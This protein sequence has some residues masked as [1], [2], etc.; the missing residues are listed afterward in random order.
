VHKR[1]LSRGWT[2]E[3]GKIPM[4][5]HL[6]ESK[7]TV[8]RVWLIRHAEAVEADTFAGSDLERPLTARG[9]RL[10]RRLFT[11]LVACYPAPGVVIVSKAI[12]ARQTGDVFTRI[13]ATPKSVVDGAVN[14]GAS[15]RSLEAVVAEALKSNDFIVVI[16][17]EPDF[18][19]YA[20]RRLGM[21]NH[22][23][24][25]KKSGLIELRRTAGSDDRITLL[26]TPDVIS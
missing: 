17:H 19:A 8:K 5:G 1:K 18:S 20:A 25:L 13:F 9:R 4:V 10:A 22:T 21:G 15:Y 23:L 24:V 12:R 26:L 14:P 7:R 11:H 6:S 2:I 3:E 16:G